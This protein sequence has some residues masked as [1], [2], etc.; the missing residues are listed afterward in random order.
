VKPVTPPKPVTS[1]K[2]VTPTKPETP[3]NPPTQGKFKPPAGATQ[4]KLPDGS[5]TYKTKSGSE[6]NADKN[7]HLSS[8]SH[9]D[10]RASFRQDGKVGSIHTKT[11]DINRSVHG[12][13]TVVTR[14][15]DGSRVVGYGRGRGFVEHP[16]KRGGREFV[17]RTY[18]GPHGHPY[19]RVYGSYRW[20][21]GNYSYYVH[22]FFYSPAFYGWAYQPW[23]SP[24]YW[25]IGA[26]GWGREPWW[27]F[28][29]GYLTPYPYYASPASWLMDYLL[30]ANL[31]VAYADAVA[32][33]A[34]DTSAQMEDARLAFVP[35][36]ADGTR[37]LRPGFSTAGNFVSAE[38]YICLHAGATDSFSFSV[39]PGQTQTVAY[40]IPTGGFVNNTSAEVS[41]NGVTA[42]T[43]IQGLGGL[44]V[45][46][47]TQL[48]LWRK[49]FGPGDYVLTIRS[50][51]NSVNVY[52]L[53]LGTSSGE[54][55]MTASVQRG[56]EAAPAHAPGQEVA[57]SPETKKLIA[58]EVQRRLQ[59]EQAAAASQQMGAD[60]DA[61]PGA[62]DPTER[63]FVVDTT[64]NETADGQECGLS[65]GDVITRLR[66]DTPDANQNV[67]VIVDSSKSGDCSA[68]TQLAV[69]VQ[70]L[71][72][73]HNHFQ[74]QLDAGM[75]E[76]K[77][78]Q[79]KNGMP[80]APGANVAPT[81]VA[82][83]QAQPDGDAE[84]QLQQQE[85]QANQI[86]I[87]VK[88]EVTAATSGGQT[89]GLGISWNERES[90]WEGIWRRRASSNIFDATWG[91]G[92]VKAVLTISIQGTAVKVER[93]NSSDGN[94][95]DYHG[96]LAADGV[97]V[98]GIYSCERWVRGGPWRAT[99]QNAEP[100][101]PLGH[102][103][104]LPWLGFANGNVAQ[105]RDV[106]LSRNCG[107]FKRVY[108]PDNAG[109]NFNDLCG[110]VSKTC[111]RVCDWEGRS[112][113]CDAV[114]LGGN[115][116]GTR[117][118][119]CRSSASVEVRQVTNDLRVAVQPRV[120][121]PRSKDN[122]PASPAATFAVGSHP[123]G[124]AFDGSNIWVV[125]N[126]GNTVTKLRVSDVT[127]MGT[128]AVGSRPGGAAFDGANI[129][130]VNS[131]S[132]SVTKLRA[133][134]G[135]VLSTT[136]GVGCAPTWA[137][138]DGANIWVSNSQ[139]SKV[140]KIRASDGTVLAKFAVGDQPEGL[141]FD[142]ANIWVANTRSNSVTKL[143][144]S[145]GTVL[146][147]F[148]V[149]TF[150]E[151]VAFDGTNM[152]VTNDMSGTVTKL[153]ASNGEELGTFR[154]GTGPVGIAFDGVNIWVAN[155]NRGVG[156]GSVTELNANGEVLGTFTVGRVPNGVAFDGA[157]I[158]VTNEFSD[159]VSKLRASP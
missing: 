102:D 104:Q 99:I 159:S 9:G 8:Y 118:A 65:A 25:G 64:L 49:T 51:G 139:C 128:F 115:R 112:I 148:P 24:V 94:N 91:G 16:F 83:G 152:W 154:V 26:W 2:P 18:W 117:V 68:G 69:A 76:L 109:N 150:P 136:S 47:P 121:N 52:G 40:G 15:P 77:K 45:T 34:A 82:D 7:G 86:E 158:W 20:R 116:D 72:D 145:D 42:A 63:V 57:L 101:S 61:A 123:Y 119:L 62:L 13:R 71:Q 39:P 140:T 153:L 28:Y 55:E 27:D 6:F 17:R 81:N 22:P 108:V 67:N 14:L 147:T 103:E 151:Q 96:T 90:G 41:V 126:F 29:G 5:S 31:Q 124:M 85:A 30:A 79:G 92:E 46:T 133:S 35:I 146:G 155:N 157:Y 73:M 135:T 131:Q 93:R 4:T 127:N 111:E 11:M 12:G 1:T 74:E 144:A 138:F 142:G 137:V 44:G 105:D 106:E 21:G 122:A 48:L 114:S 110:Y 134:D 10:T 130:V 60:P 98:S 143:R 53:W 88:S 97:T 84:A 107:D 78:N 59:A 33:A 23:G 80:A 156:N 129:W 70:D 141:A 100:V 50:G 54:P 149:G 56:S 43:I 36:F 3:T 66:P 58:E 38:D 75:D 95:C 113:S 19:A 37:A 89:D 132:S 32:P 87:E 120:A 125:N